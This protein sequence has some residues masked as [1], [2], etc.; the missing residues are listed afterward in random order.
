MSGPSA[1]VEPV[2]ARLAPV[3]LAEIQEL[4]DLQTRVDRKYVV[5]AR[6][7]AEML[8]EQGGLKVLEIGGRR[9]FGYESV[10]FDTPGLDSYRGAA[11]GRRRRFKVRTRSYADSGECVV[12][13]K[14]AGGRGETVKERLGYE[15]AAA[16]ALD[17]RAR[18][19]A[20]EVLTQTL[21]DARTVVAT[22]AAT[23]VT[24]YDRSTLVD[25]DAGTRLTCD[26]SLLCAAAGPG[27]TTP[28]GTAGLGD[29]VVLESKS[30][31]P[32]TPVDRWLWARGY[33]P[34][35]LSKYC[36]GL[37]ALDRTLP[38]NRWSRTLRRHVR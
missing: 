10:Y 20:E 9:R 5:P 22:L 16:A 18:G 29:Q 26:S 12:E 3:T 13:V 11:H 6:I 14:V 31:G 24:T 19:F 4:A 25:P 23:L 28:A 35:R 34:V 15:R 38:S 2:L 32:A 30:P 33:R 8:A 7:V 1:Q 37:A 27:G 21:P 36:V 17:E